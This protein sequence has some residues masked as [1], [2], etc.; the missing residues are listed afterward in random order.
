METKLNDLFTLPEFVEATMK[1]Y[2]LELSAESRQN[3]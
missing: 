2:S 1:N 3:T